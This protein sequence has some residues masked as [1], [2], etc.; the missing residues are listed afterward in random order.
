MVAVVESRG[1]KVI[2][3][4]SLKPI[5][6]DPRIAAGR[7]MRQTR[8]AERVFSSAIQPQ[9]RNRTQVTENDQLFG[10]LE[11]QKIRAR[12]DVL[13]RGEETAPVEDA[14][15]DGSLFIPDFGAADVEWV[16]HDGVPLELWREYIAAANAGAFDFCAVAALDA[17]RRRRERDEARAEG[18]A[19]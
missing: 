14:V 8:K 11:P 2:W 3:Q 5:P 16:T 19:R 15:A 6:P 9:S 10:I 1:A 17:H 4:A 13:M 18:G 7:R 12:A